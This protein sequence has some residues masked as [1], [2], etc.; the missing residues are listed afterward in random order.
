MSD[1]QAQIA[2]FLK[3]AGW[4][5]A[6]RASLAG[7]ASARRYDRLT[8][9]EPPFA[10]VLM[11]AP[12]ERGEDIKP[13]LNIAHFLLN[14][15]F[16]APRIYAQNEQHGLILMEDLGDALFARVCAKSNGLEPT[17]YAAA[18]DALTALHA[19][20]PPPDLQPYSLD[21]YEREACLLTDW[22]LPAVTGN[23]TS[24]TLRAEFV[25]LIREACAA[26]TD[27]Q[28][29]C[30]LRDYHA[31]NLLWLPDRKG[32]ARVGQLDFQ[33]A[34]LGH[35]AYDLVSLLE[36]ARRDTSDDLQ[37]SMIARYLTASNLDPA[38]FRQAYA[39]LGAQRNLKI[40]GIFVRLCQRDGKT[41]YVD[42]IPHVWAHLQK[43][44]R[45][46]ALHALKAFMDRHVPAPE[47]AV[48]AQITAGAA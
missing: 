10:A 6:V 2:Q 18:V 42:L 25:A 17:L 41:G 34:L 9:L 8:R 4:Q 28:T 39:T 29:I 40:I 5:D 11:D 3:S 47:P 21:V 26:L 36:D 27:D 32:H 1:R 45:H 23:A 46:P 43:D 20:P 31:E 7:D 48:L 22:Y 37:T 35:P 14:A 44:L 13:F 15:G 33:D 30:V 12:P 19:T 24:T 38:A 16:S